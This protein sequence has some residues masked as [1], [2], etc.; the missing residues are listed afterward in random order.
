MGVRVLG[1]LDVDEGALS[2]R[3]RIVLSVLIL[4]AGAVVGPDELA[5]AL[6]PDT[7]A[8]TW[9]KQVQATITRLRR[10][11][12]PRMIRTTA[13]GY[14]VEVDP[15][16]VDAVRF[17]RLVASARAHAGDEDPTRAIDGFQRALAL[18]RGRPY[19]DLAAWPPG[20]AEADRLSEIRANAD[21]ELAAQR[22]RIGEHRAVIPEAERLVRESPLREERWVLLATALYRSGRQADALSAIRSARERLGTELGIDVGEDLE[23]LE[24]A[25]L[26]HDP[27]LA[28]PD[29]QG[30]AS[31]TCPYRGLQPFGV[32]DADEFFG[33]DAD[34]AAALSRLARSRFL[35]VSGASGSG[36]SSLVRAGVVPALQR[37]GDRV[38]ILTPDHDLDIRLR[39]A[40]HG[41]GRADVMVIDQFEEVF[42]S[43]RADVDAAARAVADAVSAGTT[44]ILVVRSDFLDDCAAHPDLAPLVAEGVHLVGPMS[45]EALRQAIEE[46][47]RRAGLRLEPG[48]V[49]IILRDAA[50]EAGA[51]PHMSHALVETWLRREGAT[52]TVA[53]YEASGGISGAIAQSADRLYQSMDTE[54]RALCRSVL[55]RL[56]ALSPEGNPVRR[57]VSAKPLR[58]D[59]AREHVLAMLA[60]SRLVSAEADTVAVAHESLATAWPRLHAWLEEDAESSR[61]LA[62]VSTGA[63]AWHAD[64]RPD[65]EL[66]RGGRLQATLDWREASAPDLTTIEADYLEASAARDRSERRLEAER[67]RR[68]RRQNIRLRGAL[69]AAAALLVG[70]V[71]ASA[72]VFVKSGEAEQSALDQQIEALTSTS[73]A[74]R[75]SDPGV[76]ALLAAEL[77]R[78]WPDDSRSLSALWGS[79]TIGEGLVSRIRYE[80]GDRLMGAPIPGGRTAILVRDTPSEDALTPVVSLVD[81]DRG[82]EIRELP[83]ELPP[84]TSW[85]PRQVE[86]SAD[87]SVAAVQTSASRDPDDP[88]TC[89]RNFIDLIDLR[90]GER[91]VDTIELDSRTGNA[92]ALTPDGSRVVI[93]HPVTAEL[94]VIDT[95]TGELLTP[96]PGP[97]ERFEGVEGVYT[98]V[99]VASDG[100]FLV[101]GPGGVIVHDPVSFEPVDLVPLP[102]GM[103]EWIVLETDDGSIFVS[104]MDAMAVVGRDGE[105]RWRSE[106]EQVTCITAVLPPG[107]GTLLC[108]DV[109]GSIIE[110]DL[111]SGEPTGRNFPSLSDQTYNLDLLDD[112]EFVTVAE[113][114]GAF[115]AH[116]RLDQAASVTTA[117]ADGRIVVDGFGDGGRL[118]ITAPPGWRPEED[119]GGLQL[120]DI[121]ADAPVG[122][123][124]DGLHW[125]DDTR[126]FSRHGDAAPTLVDIETGESME[127]PELSGGGA[128]VNSTVTLVSGGHGPLAFVIDE[129]RVIPVDPATG[130]QAGATLVVPDVELAAFGA[131]VAELGDGHRVA[132][133][134]FD[135][136][137]VRL[138]TAVF[139]LDSG[140]ELARGL[141]DD[142]PVAATGE[143]DL[144]SASTARLTRSD[145]ELNPLAA[146]PTSGVAARSLQLTAG[147]DLLLLDDW[148]NRLSLYDMADARRLG[149]PLPMVAQVAQNFPA[150]FLSPDGRRIVTNSAEGVLV[151]DIRPERLA[152]AACR[153]VGREFSALEWEAYFGDEPQVATCADLVDGGQSVASE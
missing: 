109:S 28:P 31:E 85:Y 73:L 58:A 143:D 25:I 83:V 20:A 16:A 115:L 104:G 34:V 10:T 99:S 139:D 108:R 52:L 107:S 128:V 123:E 121:E 132:V 100:S 98:T 145:A 11:L 114:E 138:L 14:A 95:A 103:N 149:T 92:F 54:Q 17:E 65:D 141:A 33:R 77:H 97:P 23:A 84:A 117:I 112:D 118:I 5:D 46:P 110:L 113:R 51:L 135:P 140:E 18:W 3:E 4:R 24:L 147:Q 60:A 75:E 47:A 90:S 68:D 61:I 64:G 119:G 101:G 88:S 150:S 12:G 81:I 106:V 136:S 82:T 30:A 67:A 9:R 129:D 1:P 153:M 37:R 74:L 59:A 6:W 72:F 57:R 49:E 38:S 126:V 42:H 26:R 87:G 120:W 142:G 76:A 102:D 50:G 56:V 151:W 36:K 19:P 43:G 70:M 41:A 96:L 152:E 134:W 69:A 40:V 32:D 79:V 93:I 131:S 105:A 130:R 63:E 116:W 80:H 146:L 125:A 124:A 137:E 66:L 144:L 111:E 7:P 2:P 127:L 21:E 55:M 53:G 39:D 148:D 89:C 122:L 91:L 44:L 48:L 8:S 94:I 71:V 78:R 15:E 45:P 29:V 13:H 133:N 27:T 22:L 62:V 35:A 86:V